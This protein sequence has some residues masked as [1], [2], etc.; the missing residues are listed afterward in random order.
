MGNV[1]LKDSDFKPSQ[2]NAVILTGYFEPK[3][4]LAKREPQSQIKLYSDGF[5]R[6][7][8]SDIAYSPADD[9][10][11]RTSTYVN[12]HGKAKFSNMMLSSFADSYSPRLLPQYLDT[13]NTLYREKKLSMADVRMMDAELCK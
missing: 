8:S 12:F 2:C 1:V 6:D 7:A 3:G 11:L 5:L 4:H 9:E 10:K 13:Y